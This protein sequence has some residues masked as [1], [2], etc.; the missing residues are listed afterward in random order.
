MTKKKFT[1]KS[2]IL[3][4]LIVI[5]GITIAFW[6]NNWG[7]ERKERALEIEFLKTLR[8]DLAEDSIAF[9]AQVRENEKN[10][11]QL[12][13]FIRLLRSK[14]YQNAAIPNKHV[15]RFLNRNNWIVNG[16]T[17]EILKS[18][19]KLDIITNSEL[20]NDISLFFRLRT[21]QSE[22][23]LDMSQDF[24]DNQ[25]NIYLSKNSDYFIS[26][27]PNLDFI[28]EK[29]FQNLLVIWAELTEDNLGAYEDILNDIEDLITRLD[30]E[31]K[32]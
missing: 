12:Y 31:L 29:E 20:R 13:T 8:S 25:M 18:G 23:L 10:V 28:K 5:V 6:V 15:G 27:K 19:G 4:I 22:R 14:D 1:F 30:T 3:E 16:N 9:A 11:E 32:R 26:N 24:V 2:I 7:E 21:F 17:F